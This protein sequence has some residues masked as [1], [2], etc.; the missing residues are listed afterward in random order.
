MH[1]TAKTFYIK[2]ESGKEVTNVFRVTTPE[3][4]PE[5]LRT[6]VKFCEDGRILIANVDN[7]TEHVEVAH[8]GEVVAFET[9]TDPA[10]PEG[11]NLWVK[12]NAAETLQEKDGKF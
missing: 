9:T 11:Y 1:I 4:V 3:S 7:K 10:L 12:G 6:S 2:K 5:K 8:I